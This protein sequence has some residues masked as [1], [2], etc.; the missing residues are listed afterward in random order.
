[1]CLL[2]NPLVDV[3]IDTTNTQHALSLADWVASAREFSVNKP[4]DG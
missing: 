3:K 2:R 4:S 1:M